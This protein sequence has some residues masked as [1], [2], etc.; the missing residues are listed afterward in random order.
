MQL[1]R[2][3]ILLTPLIL[4]SPA[5]LAELRIP[6]IFGDGMVIQRDRPIH[7]W[8]HAAS[9]ENVQVILGPR[10]L[11][12]RADKDGKWSM[13]L[14]PLQ[15]SS[16][17]LSLNIRSAGKTVEYDNIL[18]GDVW[19]LGGQSNMED[20]LESIYHGDTEVISANFP[21]IR[22]MTIPQK[23]ANKKQE[24]IERI[25]EFNAWNNRYEMKGQWQICTPKSVARFSAI[26]Y[27]FGRRL[28]MASGIPIGLIDASVGGTTVEAWTSRAKL[29]NIPEAKPLTDEW[30]GKISTY[31]ATT[32]LAAKVKNWEKD[33]ERRRTRGEKPNPKPTEPAQDPA[34]DRNNPGASYNAMIAPIAGFNI[35]GT[36]FNQGYNN[37][38]GNARPR[39]YRQTFQAMI[40]GWRSSFR[41]LEMP[42]AIIGLTPGGQPQTLDNFELRMVDPA[43]YI[44]EAQHAATK[45]LKNTAY[46]PAYDQQVPWYHPHKKFEL[47]ERAARWALN[48][49]YGHKRIGWKPVELVAAENRGDHFELTFEKPIRVHDG[50][51][52]SGFSIAGENQH[53]V[54]AT[55]EFVVT[56]Q[57]KHK[58]DQHDEK[59]LKISSPLV[60]KPV[61]VRYA[62]SRNP[63][64]NA[65]NSAHHER[66]IPIPS[67]RT[68]NW[69]WPEASFT[70]QGNDAGNS[71]REAIRDLRNA[72]R[73]NNIERIKALKVLGTTGN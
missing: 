56:G 66:T 25:N 43:P 47:G 32:S 5:V 2:L 7:V 20:V 34:S 23:A 49:C 68:D 70:A 3:I 54:P 21:T 31:D 44:R 41:D 10:D 30:D 18:I 26:G 38:L 62:W 8:G 72:A 59:R 55:A 28:R 11:S 60:E 17:A 61:A 19:L 40:E 4:G 46:L 37:A 42:F 69:N 50:R 1:T 64:G 65:V 71:H 13:E 51:P 45:A 14:E 27:I 24:D 73:D 63:L 33:T 29:A 15:A 22:L 57:D 12:T 35:R 39:L 9:E 58:R 53:F 6:K 52:F 36:I 67:F 16:Q 48:T